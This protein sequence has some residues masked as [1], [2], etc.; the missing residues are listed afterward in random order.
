[1]CIV[2]ASEGTRNASRD[3]ASESAAV[4]LHA[5]IACA[6]EAGETGEAREAGEAG[7][8]CVTECNAASAGAA[9]TIAPGATRAAA[10][11]SLAVS[12]SGGISARSTLES[13]WG[14]EGCSFVLPL[15]PRMR[16]AAVMVSGDF[17]DFL[18]F[19]IEV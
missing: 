3:R 10:A 11:R 15:E 7:D 12:R 9:G 4:S 5:R 16:S 13:S 17:V 19:V 14:R 8:E 2:T 18:T 6:G 1:M